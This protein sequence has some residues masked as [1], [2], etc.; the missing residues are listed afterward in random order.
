MKD[1]PEDIKKKVLDGYVVDEKG[2]W[3]TINDKVE[4]ER[5]FMM[6][7]EA[8]EVL[9]D[10]KWTKMADVKKME[11]E[12][13]K[14]INQTDSVL[15]VG[16]Y[17]ELEE[18]RNLQNADTVPSTVPN[19][20]N[21]PPVSPKTKFDFPVPEAEEETKYL[22]IKRSTIDY[23]KNNHRESDP[24]EYLEETMS[25]DMKSIIEPSSGNYTSLSNNKTPSGRKSK[26]IYNVAN[27][28][29]HERKRK[30]LLFFSVSFTIALFAILGA[31]ALAF[32]L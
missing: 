17:T 14:K 3:V 8:G 7:L 1:A 29:E 30:Q 31:V 20:T 16:T 11:K 26:E 15:A 23:Y 24:N 12:K 28:W 10:G 21:V 9:C 5:S 25:F 22:E 18:T 4:R 27:S 19:S 2:N 6:H 13:Q 32:L